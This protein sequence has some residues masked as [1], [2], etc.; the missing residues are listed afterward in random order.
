MSRMGVSG[1]VT[2]VKNP[3]GS[4]KTGEWKREA[5]KSLSDVALAIDNDPKVRRI[6]NSLGIKTMDPATI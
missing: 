1:S 2:P 5:A 6:Y 4:D 3:Y